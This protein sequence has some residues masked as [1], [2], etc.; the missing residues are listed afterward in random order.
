MSGIF[1]L[2]RRDGAPVADG[3]AAMRASMQR[4]GPDGFGEWCGCDAALGQAR[5]AAT[6]ESRFEDLPAW[7]DAAGFAFT[8]AGRLDNRDALV[9]EL[10]LA[11]GGRGVGDGGVLMAA[12]ARWGEDAPRRLLG[13]WAFAAWHART[14]RLFL[15]RDQL[16]Q[17]ALYYHCDR[18]VAAFSSSLSALLALGVTPVRLDELWLGQYLI[19]W[20]AY[21]GATTPSSAARRLAPA[22]TLDVT[23]DRVR[24]NCYWRLEDQ[25]E[26]PRARRSDYVMA[27]RDVFDEAVRSRLRCQGPVCVMLSGGLDSSAVAATAAP[28]LG[29]RGQRL[30]AFTAVPVGAARDDRFMFGDELPLVR[31]ISQFADNIDVVP[32]PAG[33]T[34]PIAGIRWGLAV[35]GEPMHAASNMFWMLDL[36]QQVRARGSSVVLNGAL[37]NGSISWPGDPLSQPLT[38]QLR[39]LGVQGWLRRRGRRAVPPVVWRQWLKRRMDPHW[40]RGSAIAPEFERRLDLAERRV[41]DP[42]ALIR[43]PRDLRLSLLHPGRSILGSNMAALA[44]WFGLEGRDPTGDVRVLELTLSVPD[45]V[46]RAPGGGAPRWLVREAMRERL[47]DEVRLN[48]RKGLQA[49]DLVYRLRSCAPDVDEA[50]DELAAGAAAA[51]VDVAYMRSCW[52]VIRRQDTRDAHRMAVSVLAR[53]I[54]GGLFANAVAQGRLPGSGATDASVQLN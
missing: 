45:A 30:T 13:D 9:A 35:Y 7:D 28:M 23:P 52:R 3:L 43:T 49:A 33:A 11:H 19:S 15:A 26:V 48:R 32:V 27:L 34:N 4:W 40:Y 21:H 37:G 50:L 12:Y 24:T 25:P 5:L 51:Y 29:E 2:I 6:P 31:S 22:H 36:Y 44:G 17:T 39:T 1:G 14:R 8:A 53:G 16:G 41:G 18:N 20:R 46:F 38:G 54:M 42:A 47:P 10:G